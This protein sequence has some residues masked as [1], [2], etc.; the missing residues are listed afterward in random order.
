MLRTHAFKAARIKTLKV[1][2]ISIA[3]PNCFRITSI[4]SFILNPSIT[5]SPPSAGNKP[6]KI[7]IAYLSYYKYNILQV[8]NTREPIESFI[9][10]SERQFR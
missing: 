5:A 2:M 8:E 6:V 9:Q 3:S 7:A 4:C 10:V 1:V